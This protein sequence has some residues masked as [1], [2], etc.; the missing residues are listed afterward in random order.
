MD[1]V[2]MQFVDGDVD[3]ETLIPSAYSLRMS[4]LY[5]GWKAVKRS[6]CKFLQ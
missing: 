1:F 4:H 5:H 3:R 6:S 2:V